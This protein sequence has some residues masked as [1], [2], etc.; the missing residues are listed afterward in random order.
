MGAVVWVIAATAFIVVVPYSVTNIHF[1]I[2]AA[3]RRLATD[4]SSW[5]A[6]RVDR[7]GDGREPPGVCVISGVV[8]G[9]I[10]NYGPIGV[11]VVTSDVAVFESYMPRL[12]RPRTVV[13]HRGVDRIETDGHNV[14]DTEKR[15]AV[16]SSPPS[17]LVGMLF[18][19]GW[20]ER[21]LPPAN[22]SR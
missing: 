18:A 21:P 9:R 15:V 20:I 17:D 19:T 11:A 16:S 8:N 1:R 22:T 3:R 6:E 14:F 7:R 10:E 13:L 12:N 4:P 2:K 5:I